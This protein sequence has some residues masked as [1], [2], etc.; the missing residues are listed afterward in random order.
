MS[1]RRSSRRPLDPELKNREVALQFTPQA[2]TALLLPLAL[3]AQGVQAEQRIG[4]QVLWTSF[5]IRLT[6]TLGTSGLNQC[7]FMLI[8]D[9]M[10]DQALIVAADILSQPGL[11]IVSPLNLQNNKRFRVLYDRVYSWSAGGPSA[12]QFLNLYKK[13]N[14]TTRYGG[15]GTTID[16]V[17]SNSLWWCVFSASAAGEG[18]P[19]EFV[20]RQRFVG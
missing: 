6:M 10:P 20:T 11:A 14:H 16:A 3:V 13:L 8:L 5:Q 7:R 12:V 4:N 19:I 1:G 18:A 15:N 17:T 9:K 2:G